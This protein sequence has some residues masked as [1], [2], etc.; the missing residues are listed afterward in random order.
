L[1]DYSYV[2]DA[3][4]SLYEATFEPS[5]I[6]SALDLARVMLEQFWDESEGGF[7]F[8]GRDHEPLI[9]RTKDLLDNATPSGNAMAAAA[10][11]RLAK[12]TGRRD[13][14]DR[15]EATFRLCRD[16]MAERP[17]GCGQM[18]IALDFHL[19][20]VQ[21]FAVVGDPAG[22]ESR[23]VLRT[24]RG[25]FRPNKVVAMKSPSDGTVEQVLPVLAGKTATDSVTTYVCQDFVCQAPLAGAA[26]V[27][28]ALG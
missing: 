27:E 28:A 17:M 4:V 21:E 26:A 24:I 2:I 10:L 16:L 8:T 5:W 13:L 15:A 1:E 20:P 19:G 25:R 14:R 3:L 11:L 9:T 22:E 18:L 12:L 7:Y 6:V 23:R